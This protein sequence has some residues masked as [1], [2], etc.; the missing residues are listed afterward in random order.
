MRPRWY[1]TRDVRTARCL[2]N[3]RPC[4]FRATQRADLRG[5][6]G[7][8][9]DARRAR[10]GP[11]HLCVLTQV[12]LA[13]TSKKYATEPPNALSPPGARS[14]ES[15]PRGRLS[16]TS[17]PRVTD[18]R[19]LDRTILRLTRRRRNPPLSCQCHTWVRSSLHQAGAP[20]CT[21]REN[22]CGNPPARTS[23]IPTTSIEALTPRTASPRRPSRSARYRSTRLRPTTRYPSSGAKD[24]PWGSSPLGV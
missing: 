14:R 12:A 8:R 1:L 18:D 9:L 4:G 23:A 7:R 17:H 6:V 24:A 15:T 10:P 11:D 20:V 3:A 2:V 13:G 22:R 5:D 19:S 21:S 16:Q